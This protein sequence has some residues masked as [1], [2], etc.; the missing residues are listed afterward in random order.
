MK[1]NKKRHY[2]QGVFKP[3]NPTKYSGTYPII[4]RSG[5]ELR[6]F[7][8]LDKNPKILQWSS[9][10]IIVPYTNPL[11]GRVHR[12]FVD[13]MAMMRDEKGNI[14]KYL[15]EIKPYSKLT[16]P[17]ASNKR[18]PQNTIMLQR[19]YIQNK[20]KWTAASQWSE[21]HGYRFIILTEKHLIN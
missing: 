16:P 4:Y 13:N 9:E 10:S 5:L 6:Y 17:P 8:F 7:R 12:Y 1:N 18:K 20:A 3:L 19:E 2:K 15:I 14:V 11:T 21:K